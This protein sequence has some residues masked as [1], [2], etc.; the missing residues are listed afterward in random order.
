[1]DIINIYGSYRK[2][3]TAANI[4]IKTKPITAPRTLRKSRTGIRGLD[5][6]TGGGLPS[7][8]PTLVCGTAGCGKTLLAMEFLVRGATEYGEPGVFMAFEETS[9]ELADNVVSLGFDL[10]A[11]VARKKLLLDYVCLDR[12]E[13]EETGE[14]NLE[15]LFIRLDHAIDSIKAK[16]VVL[17]T[18]EGLFP[19]LPNQ[20]I[21]RTELRRLFRWLKEK[22]VTAIITGERGD[23]TLTRYGLEEYVSDCVISLDHRVVDQVTT[24]RIRIVKYRGTMHGT[25]EYPFL[26]EKDG[27]SIWPI[28]SVQVEHTASHERILTGIE[29]LDT[30]LGGKG[31]YRGSSI[32]LSGTAGTGKTSVAATFAEAT[33]RRGER[34]LYISF[35]ETPSNIIR[36]MA[37]IGIDLQQWVKKGQLQF[38]NVRAFHFGLEMHLVRTIKFITEF[39]PTVVI[40]D[41]ISGLDTSGTS[42]EVKAALMRLVDYLKQQGLTA[43]L[44]EKMNGSSLEQTDEAISSLV[45]T[46]LVLRDLESNGERNRGLHVLKSR[47]ME[48]SNQVREFMLSGTGI[49]LTD[50]YI[51][52]SGMLVGSAR[53][54]QEARERAERVSLSE[55]AERQQLALEC[56][57]TALDGQ[58]AAMRAEFSAEEA[59]IARIVSQDKRRKESLASD[60]VEMGRS[61]QRD[62]AQSN[63]NQ[64][65]NGADGK[66]HVK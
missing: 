50:V 40:I 66:K 52:P 27:I 42:L 26:I 2:L 6:I 37:T 49:Q 29:R 46:W 22:G 4:N 31:F 54:A 65:R 36:N 19:G 9:E 30:M 55:E 21:V 12:S 16:R 53:V 61:R 63:R 28:T 43:M 35:E 58:I 13:F 8:R 64:P 39:A 48:H 20:A 14:Y 41:P 5:E 59:T 32:L 57:R 10:K 62:A 44:T 1:M 3:A 25:N 34:C 51:G 18:I 7:G 11:L 56:K 60:K 15:G 38:Q 47:G 45:D 33:C 17:D 23:G 24:R